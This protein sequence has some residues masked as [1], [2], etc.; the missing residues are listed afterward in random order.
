MI[1]EHVSSLLADYIDGLLSPAEAEAVK[2]HLARCPD[3]REEHRFLKSYMKKAADFPSVPVPDD[4]LEKIHAR[5][6]APAP[7]GMIRRLFLPLKVKLPLEAA[8]ALALT[9][10]AVFIFRPFDERKLEYHAEAPALEDKAAAPGKEAGAQ[11]RT[12]GK[13][14]AREYVKERTEKAAPGK[15]APG[16]PGRITVANSAESLKTAP[17]EERPAGEASAEISLVLKA[18]RSEGVSVAGD[19]REAASSTLR[20]KGASSTRSDMAASEYSRIA[21]SQAKGQDRAGAIAKLATT[22]GGRV[23]TVSDSDAYGPRR[24]IIVEIPANK[25]AQFLA[26][27]RY[28]WSIRSRVPAAPPAKTGRLRITMSLED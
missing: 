7:S 28:D 24:L 1:N 6:D 26:G 14:L 16:G 22:L 13:S 3:C 9:V 10:L 27:I 18:A 8:G 11:V 2:K 4:F 23:I 15:K 12:G 5:I 25:Y 19:E 17:A 21:E 20:Q